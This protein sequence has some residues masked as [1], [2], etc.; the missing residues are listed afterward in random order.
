V[1]FAGLTSSIVAVFAETGD[2]RRELVGYGF[3]SIGRYAHTE[4]IRERFAPR[5]LSAASEDYCDDQGRLDPI[6]MEALMRR[7]EK[8]G[9][10][11]ERPVAI[12][13]V[14]MA[15]WDLIGKV[16]EKPLYQILSERFNGGEVDESVSVYAAGGYYYAEGGLARLRQE[17][18]RYLSLGYDAVKIKIGAGSI[19]EDQ[20]R[21]ETAIDCVG[22]GSSVAIDANG[23]YDCDSALAVG[24]SVEGY[25]LKWYEE[26]GDPLDYSLQNTLAKSYQ[27]CLATGEN[28]FSLQD[29][30]NLIRYGGMRPDRDVLQM[31]PGLS[32]GIPEYVRMLEFIESNGWSRRRCFPHGGNLFNLHVAQ[33]LQ[34][35]GTEAYPGVFEPFGGFGDDVEI[36]EGRASLSDTPGIGWESKPE[37][38]DWFRELE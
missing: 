28:L 19:A 14:D 5:L 11:G 10:H 7:D 6:R 36:S 9:G 33:G 37:L 8:P 24:K 17:L 18:E 22:R 4:L 27:G 2:S 38:M 35:G 1:N 34:L 12:G 29:V 16:E 32:Y 26:A 13:A 25:G 20:K 21:I 23:R 30:R 3:G 15:I 31:D